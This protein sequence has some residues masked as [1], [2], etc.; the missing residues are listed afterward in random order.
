M[1]EELFLLIFP[2]P[3]DGGIPFL[4]SLLL[5]G[6]GKTVCRDILR[7]YRTCSGKGPVA[8]GDRRNKA[9]VAADEYIVANDG[10]MLFGAI[11]IDEYR[12]AAHV[13]P[14]AHVTVANVGKMGQFRAFSNVGVLDLHEIADLAALCNVAAGTKLH[15]GAD[16]DIV[17]HDC[18]PGHH[19]LEGAAAAHR[20]VDEAAAGAEG[21][22]LL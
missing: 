1:D 20:G 10:T 17:A 13:D 19:C 8:Y 5:A 7:D 14:A 11:V 16:G 3:K 18:I 2:F 21:I 4:G 22:I 6:N 9:G 15:K 12:A